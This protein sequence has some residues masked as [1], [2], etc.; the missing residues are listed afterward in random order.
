MM[1]YGTENEWTGRQGFPEN[2]WSHAPHT[3]PKYKSLLIHCT[4]TT[5]YI[6]NT[7]LYYYVSTCIWQ[8]TK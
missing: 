6:T 3:N 2:R 7:T 8:A 5:K 4:Y 1:K